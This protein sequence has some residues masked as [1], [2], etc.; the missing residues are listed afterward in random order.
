[1]SKK[2]SQENINQEELVVK[3]FG[4]Q[5]KIYAG[6]YSD[7]SSIAHSFSIRRQ[8]VYE[9]LEELKEGKVLDI[10]CGPGV[11][12]DHLLNK[13]LEF[14]GVDLSKEMIEQ[15][16]QDFR[17]IP[18]AHFSVGRIEKI[19]FPDSFFNAVV[20]MGVVEYID[21]DQGAIRE[22]K[23][24]AK[25]G[26]FIIITLP[27]KQ[28]PYR[29]WGRSVYSRM[30]KIIKKIIKRKGSKIIVHREYSEV[31]YI[32]LLKSFDL[33]VVDVVYYNFKLLLSPLDKIAPKLNVFFSR[34]LEFLSRS[35]LRWL[36]TGFIVKAK[37]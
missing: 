36:G 15:C 3:T 10:G 2:M 21:D 8:R 6:K 34:Q 31:K 26:G 12:V 27:N 28:S 37:K 20:C 11:M 24:V 35:K 14:Y 4:A 25:P 19:E 18:S 7:K 33:K 13:G 9:M 1:M 32:E 23:R 30:T 22:M 16:K 17:H 29:V 5:A